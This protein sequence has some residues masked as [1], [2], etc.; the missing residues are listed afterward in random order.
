MCH[1]YKQSKCDTWAVRL[2]FG[3]NHI[4][5]KHHHMAPKLRHVALTQ[6]YM[7]FKLSH[8]APKL[9]MGYGHMTTQVT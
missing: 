5:F 9:P 2:T 7:A 3:L 1:N 6:N 4:T 8:V